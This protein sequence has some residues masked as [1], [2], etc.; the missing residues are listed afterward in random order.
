M[1]FEI[2]NGA[3]ITGSLY[4]SS[5][6]SVPNGQV[7]CVLLNQGTWANRPSTN[8][9]VGRKY[10]VIE[11]GTWRHGLEF[12]Y[13][14]VANATWQTTQIF[15]FPLK[16]NAPSGAG[17]YNASTS[18]ALYGVADTLNSNSYYKIASV[19]TTHHYNMVTD[20]SNY[21]RFDYYVYGGGTWYNT[22][23]W[24]SYNIGSGVV[25]Y[26]HTQSGQ[27]GTPLHVRIDVIKIGSPTTLY[28]YEGQFNYR[29]IGQN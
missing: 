15:N 7:D 25:D 18:G 19:G 24:Y 1:A 29:L 12:F 5:N 14:G 6:V 9:V 27:Y 20:T 16:C 17:T 2:L 26:W 8:L 3:S 13:A 23:L 11:P 28:M 4:V 22:A 21:W 10:S